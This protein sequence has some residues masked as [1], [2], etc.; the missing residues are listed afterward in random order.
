VVPA[1]KHFGLIQRKSNTK[2]SEPSVPFDERYKWYTVVTFSQL[3]IV[4]A[5]K[6]RLTATGARSLAAWERWLDP[7]SSISAMCRPL[8][9]HPSQSC[10]TKYLDDSLFGN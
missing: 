6:T 3:C 7:R 5:C 10:P 8:G 9:G 4:T 2:N 1:V